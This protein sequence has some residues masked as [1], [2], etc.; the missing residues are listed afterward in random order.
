MNKEYYNSLQ[1]EQVLKTQTAIKLLQYYSP[2]E[3]IQLLRRYSVGGAK[4][5]KEAWWFV[6]ENG[7]PYALTVDNKDYLGTPGI[8]NVKDIVESKAVKVAI[9]DTP[10]QAL[11]GNIYLRHYAVWTYCGLGSDMSVFKD[12]SCFAVTNN[13]DSPYIRM[14]KQH[15]SG[16]RIYHYEDFKEELFKTGAPT[17]FVQRPGY[18]RKMTHFEFIS[19][20]MNN[21]SVKK[22]TDALALELT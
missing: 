22:L 5:G 9:C 18:K 7:T 2:F 1:K 20:V 15:V 10:E 3:T 11:W 16:I 4:G 21:E 12:K 17:P 14:L 19:K 8:W 6:N 13:I